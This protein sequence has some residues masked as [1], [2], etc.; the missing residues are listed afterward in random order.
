M[1]SSEDSVA[2]SDVPTFSRCSLPAGPRAAAVVRNL[3]E[4]GL[5]LR[6]S[7]GY[8]ADGRE[9]VVLRS[10]EIL[11]LELSG[12]PRLNVIA[13][14]PNRCSPSQRWRIR[15]RDCHRLRIEL[16]GFARHR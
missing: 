16:S 12:H 7:L 1:K 6:R 2:N 15:G 14:L 8:A 13:R 5:H 9:V 4:Q 3:R 11:L 10:S